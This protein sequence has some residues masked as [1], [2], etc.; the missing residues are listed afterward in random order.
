[1]TKIGHDSLAT[2]LNL[3]IN[4]KNY[5]YYSLPT[6]QKQS[7]NDISTLPFCL[8]VLLENLLRFENGKT[9]KINDIEAIA[10]R[11][12]KGNHQTDEIAYHPARVLMQD[13]TG[14]PAVADLAA[15]RQA[16]KDIGA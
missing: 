7:G 1:M 12:N 9:V 14:V 6:Y 10:K 11:A 8:K 15:M 3:N 4:G 13:F 2:R 5:A 16:M